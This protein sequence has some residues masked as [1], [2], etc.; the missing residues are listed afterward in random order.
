M[1]PAPQDMDTRSRSRAVLAAILGNAFEW[2]DFGVFG[3]MTPVISSLFFPAEGLGQADAV[4]LTTALFGTGFIT[5]PLGGIVLGLY[6]DRYGHQR[7]MVLGMSIMAGAMALMACAPPYRVGG[8][9][10]LAMVIAARLLQGFSV[11]GEFATSTT[12]L[13]ELA[14]PGQ[15]GFF[16]SWQITGQVMAQIMG[17]G[18]GYLV[19]S[20]FTHA[21]LYA[22]AWRIPFLFGLMILPLVFTL[23]H[24]RHRPAPGGHAISTGETLAHLLGQRPQILVGMGLVVASTVS[25]YVIYAYVVT[26]AATVLH[27]PMVHSYQVQLVAA[28]AMMLVVPFSGYLS[29]RCDR[30]AIMLASLLA[31]AIMIVPLYIW[32]VAAPSIARLL[33]L[34]VALSVASGMFLGTYCTFL[35]DLVSPQARATA[36][37]IINNLVVLLVGGFAQFIVTWLIQATG[38]KIAPSFF[39]LGGIAM[40]LAALASLPA[41]GNRPAGVR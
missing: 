18:L 28:G 25:F 32:L 41:S 6:G 8:A 33:V 20:L 9:L 21:Q 17:A 35:V 40:G 34:Q 26:Y 1:T 10:S 2:Y 19:T 27:L 38:L 3:F 15:R 13:I 39:V 22:Y 16:G 11:G 24:A 5:R 12:A 36:L 31:Y 7:A 30:R 4:L 14:P 37:A 23:R 29:D